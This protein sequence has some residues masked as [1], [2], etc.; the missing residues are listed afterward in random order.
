MVADQT[1]DLYGLLGVS[2]AAKDTEV[3]TLAGCLSAVC[4]AHAAVMLLH[5][6]SWWGTFRA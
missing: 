3:G 2:K 1:S 4:A 6:G 5:D